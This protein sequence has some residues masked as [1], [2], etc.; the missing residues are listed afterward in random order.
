VSAPKP[1]CIPPERSLIEFPCLFPIKVMGLDVEGFADAMTAIA[2]E[3]DPQYDP[4]TLERR[5][6]SGGKYL[7]LTL[8]VTVHSRQQLDDLYRRL[9]GHDMV[10]VAL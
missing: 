7:G 1:E 4:A 5:G 2:R 9:S 6:S 3:F 8:H 10:K